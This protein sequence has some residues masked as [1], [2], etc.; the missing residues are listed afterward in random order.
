MV[1]SASV[2]QLP[3]TNS[4]FLSAGY[5]AEYIRVGSGDPIVIV[6][7]M[8]GGIALLQPLIDQLSQTN[9][10]IAYQLRG[11]NQGL[12]DRGFGFDRLVNDLGELMRALRLERPGLLGVSFGGTIALSYAARHP[13]ELAYVA[14]Q[15]VG[16]SFRLG[17]IGD[18][19]RAVLNRLPLPDDSPFLN[20]IFQVLL[21]TPARPGDQFDF[22]V[23]RCWQ[24]DQSVMAHRMTMLEDCDVGGHLDEVTTPALVF[25][26][27][28]DIIASVDQSR[29]LADR[30][31]RGRFEH[32]EEAG[33]LAFVT[34][35]ERV[36]SCVHEFGRHCQ[37]AA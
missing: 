32:L 24:T 14:V 22:V 31:A 27:D 16:A 6:P 26:C 19:A 23:N 18:V 12:F 9:E 7:G 35:P 37:K 20:Q 1:T 10:V 36:A 17:M 15:G 34:H 25:G 8:A 30:V 29:T 4:V 28:H 5:T 13:A 11:E 2:T 33:H 3:P 21:G